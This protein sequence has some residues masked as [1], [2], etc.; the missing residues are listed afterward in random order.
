MIWATVSSWSCFCWLYK[1]SPSLAAKIPGPFS[2]W[3]Y[4]WSCY[5]CPFKD[6]FSF[7]LGKMWQWNWQFVLCKAYVSLNTNA[8][9]CFQSPCACSS[10]CSAMQSWPTLCDCMDYSP[11]GPS[12]HGIFQARILEW[13]A[14]QEASGDLPDPG[15]KPVSLVSPALGFFTSEPSRKPPYY[16]WS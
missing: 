12:V 13:V 15:I 2:V 7:L 16:T 14:M 1:S 10:S 6:M 9:N 5:I 3:R 4:Q 11:P 8:P